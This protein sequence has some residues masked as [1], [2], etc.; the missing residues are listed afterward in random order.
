MENFFNGYH[1][2]LVTKLIET[3]MLIFRIYLIFKKHVA[4]TVILLHQIVDV[5]KRYLFCMPLWI[6]MRRKQVEYDGVGML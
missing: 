3:G 5:L 4:I 1:L 6:D 2:Q